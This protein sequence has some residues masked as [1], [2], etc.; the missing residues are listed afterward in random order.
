MTG[1]VNFVDPVKEWAPGLFLAS[2]AVTG[3]LVIGIL[4]LLASSASRYLSRPALEQRLQ[5]LEKKQQAQDKKISDSEQLKMRQLRQNI[6]ALRSELQVQGIPVTRTLSLIEHHLPRD[7]VVTE[8][9]KQQASGET[10]LTVQAAHAG[11]LTKFLQSLENETAFSQVR[12][13]SEDRKTLASGSVS[14][15]ELLLKD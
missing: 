9:H 3:L 8:I 14:Q 5:S 7:A 2:R 1:R 6:A 4:V 10:R 15:Y 13:V 11:E 12:L